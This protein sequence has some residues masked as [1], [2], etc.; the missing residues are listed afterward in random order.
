M[1]RAHAMSASSAV[2]TAIAAAGVITPGKAT[3]VKIRRFGFKYNP[4]TGQH[5]R[6]M[7]EWEKGDWVLWSDVEPLLKT[8]RLPKGVTGEPVKKP[9]KKP[10]PRLI[11]G[12]ELKYAAAHMLRVRYVEQY[13]NPQ[14]SH[15]NYDGVCIMKPANVG[16]YI[17]NS[18]IDPSAWSDDDAVTADFGEGVM[19]VYAVPGVNYG[20]KE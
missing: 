5:S 7:E 19:Y 16:Y 13:H 14:D 1:G 8:A 3:E 12:K 18:D 20:P 2:K 10:E 17:G 6:F 11:T 4:E 15:M 9:V